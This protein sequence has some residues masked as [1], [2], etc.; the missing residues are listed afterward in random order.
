M[1]NAS[2]G[3]IIVPV[4]AETGICVKEGVDERGNHYVLHPNTGVAL[5]GFRVPRW[6]EAVSLAKELAH[7]VKGN[8]Y[9]GWD[10]ALTEEG[11]V[12]V[13]GNPRGQFIMQIATKQG[14]KDEIE[15]YMSQI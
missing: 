2:S 6:E 7:V 9:V 11:W 15:A 8:H 14:V 1:D 10:L 4:D 5:P 12:M 3:G 13:E